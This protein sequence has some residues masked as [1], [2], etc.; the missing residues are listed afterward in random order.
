VGAVRPGWN[1]DQLGNIAQILNISCRITHNP[2]TKNKERESKTTQLK[3]QVA[4]F[5]TEL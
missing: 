3:T 5:E 2:R 4:V 1:K